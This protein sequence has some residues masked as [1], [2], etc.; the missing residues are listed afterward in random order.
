MPITASQLRANV[1]RLLDRALETGEPIQI[2]RRGQIL[3]IVP[4]ARR[5]KLDNLVPHPGYVRGD[6]EDLVHLDWSGEWK[7]DR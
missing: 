7:P 6:P 4:P 2:S 3:E 5:A 1:Y